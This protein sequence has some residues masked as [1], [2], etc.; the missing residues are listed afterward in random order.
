VVRVAYCTQVFWVLL[1]RFRVQNLPVVFANF[2]VFVVVVRQNDLLLK[3]TELE[4][5]DIVINLHGCLIGRTG[6]LPL[7]CLLLELLDLLC[8]LLGLAVEVSL[9]DLAAKNL[10]LGPVS[11]L[12]AQRDLLQDKFCLLTS[13][14]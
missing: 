10:S 11:A 4:V 12:D 5:C 9:V 7:L 3:V 13:G 2:E 6:L 8:G 14:H 1:N